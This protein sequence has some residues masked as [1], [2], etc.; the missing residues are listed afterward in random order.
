MNKRKLYLGLI[1]LF[2]TISISS[3]FAVEPQII[4]KK[5]SV[6]VIE[7][8]SVEP[9]QSLPFEK[10]SIDNALS[11]SDPNGIGIIIIAMSII[12][13]ILIILSALFKYIGYLNTSDFKKKILEKKGKSEEASKISDDAP[14]EVYAAIAMAL[15]LYQSKIHDEENTVIT[16]EKVARTYSPWSSKIYGLRQ[17]PTK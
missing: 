11:K 8:T 4:I 15:H 2:L 7:K 3:S 17:T 9:V 14:G 10:E 16:M 6:V 12:F 1:I 5:D 13:A